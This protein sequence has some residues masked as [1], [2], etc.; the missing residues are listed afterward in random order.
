MVEAFMHK[1]T[2]L[3][4]EKHCLE[5]SV[6]QLT[7]D[8]V[9]TGK[10]LIVGIKAM[11]GGAMNGGNSGRQ[12]G[13][14]NQQSQAAQGSAASA[15]IDGAIKLVQLVTLSTTLVKSCVQGDALAM[16]KETARHLVNITYL[17]KRFVVSG[18]DIVSALASSVDAFEEH[19]YHAFGADIGKALRKVLLSNATKG[20]ALPE[21]VPEEEIIRKTTEGIVK[22]FFV[23]GE[24]IEITDTQDPNVDIRLDLRRC[25][26]GNRPFF[27][28]VFLALWHAMAQFSAN[29]AQH[30][31]AAGPGQ[32]APAGS[33]T[34]W[35]GEL[36]VAM[37]QLPTALERCN[38]GMENEQMIGEAIKTMG[39]LRFHFHMPQQ[40]ANFEK[41]G[42]RMARGVEAWTHWHFREYG[43]EI[44]YMLREFVLMLYPQKYSV[45]ANGRLRRK[46]ES[47]IVA[48]KGFSAVIVAGAAFTVMLGL[49]AV[50]TMRRV[51]GTSSEEYDGELNEGELE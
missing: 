29:G 15:G 9:G 20:T 37:L 14:S 4:G 2:L 6:S 45:D 43:I 7:G 50:R 41:M 24:T 11:T 1:Q 26:A 5:N 38:L 32:P 23:R 44:G 40:R 28:E 19:R 34:K 10:D 31:L 18:V 3:P 22:G 36:M 42:D 46:L 12:D 39:S 30:G 8:I 16:L 47:T 35:T 21:G 27:K 49:I 25:I 51:Q 33:Q 13:F 48:R 17:E